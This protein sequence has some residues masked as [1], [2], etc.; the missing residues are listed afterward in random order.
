MAWVPATSSSTERHLV[1]C[2][3]LQLK[4]LRPQQVLVGFHGKDVSVLV[5]KM[6]TLGRDVGRDVGRDLGRALPGG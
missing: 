5:L 4:K 6:G 2:P 1:P 3:H